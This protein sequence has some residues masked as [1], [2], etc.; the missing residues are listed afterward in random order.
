M[1]SKKCGWT[2]E[3]IL[4]YP[5]FRFCQ[6]LEEIYE[7]DKKEREFLISLE[8][9]SIKILSKYI[10]ISS[11]ITKEGKLEMIDGIDKLF[12]TK[13]DKKIEDKKL[14]PKGSYERLMGIFSK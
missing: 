9:M 5:Y 2:D 7:D 10:V 4:D 3:Y 12:L 13:E 11:M 1:I 8:E 6:L 14:P